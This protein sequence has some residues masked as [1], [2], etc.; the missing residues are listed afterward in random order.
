M[1]LKQVLPLLGVVSISAFAQAPLTEA[2]MLKYTAKAEKITIGKAAKL[3]LPLHAQ[4]N[5][6]N[7]KGKNV[8]SQTVSHPNASYIKLHFKDV[9][10]NNG[11]TLIVRSE[12]GSERYE[13]SKLNM[14]AA[15]QLEGENGTHSFYAMSISA[16]KVVVEYVVG[17][18][19]NS[20]A[21][22]N[23]TAAV[24]ATIDGYYYGAE[25]EIAPASA[26]DMGTFSTCGAMER[27]DVQCWA[28]SNPTEFERT[29]PV[30]RLLMGGT[31]LCTGWRVGSDNRMFTNNHCV[32]STAEVANTE[33]WFNYQHT[34]CN[35]S[36]MATVVKVTG[37]ELL[38]TDYTLDYSLFTINNFEKAAPFGYFGLDVRDATQGERIYIPQH[39]AG[40]PKELSV[41]SDQDPSGL[42][43]VNE[44]NAT[45]RGTGTDLGYYCDTIG[46]SSGSP[47]LAA[48]TNKVIALHHLGGCT[49]KGAKISL[50]WPQVSSHF[51]GQIP[52]GDNG[53]TD[54][55]DPTDPVEPVLQ[56]GVAIGISGA[57]KSEQFFSFDVPANKAIVSFSLTGGSGDADLYVS[58][59]AKPTQSSYTC[60]PYK[61]G[62]EEVCTINNP[63]AGTWHVM[64]HGYQAYSGVSLKAETQDGNTSCGAD[65]LENG[66]PKTGLSGASKSETVYKIEVPAGVTLNVSTSGGTG[67]ADLYVKKGQAP[68][69]SDYDCRPYKNGNNESCSIASGT[70]GTYYIMLRGYNTYSG[71]TLTAS[72]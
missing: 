17:Q 22:E 54:P 29:R 49:N 16:D 61:N 35:G 46:G 10:L 19:K 59:G 13:Y 2:Q 67:D 31:G 65:C 62:N 72:Y 4:V 24:T 23:N 48:Q 45:G 63:T 41:E 34:S 58:Q 9:D 47:V 36:T 53:P 50:I 42:C 7:A 70:G 44:A 32:E 69:T 11:R 26:Q 8:I 60:R 30:A 52:N 71:L 57:A 28:E 20:A 5:T 6:F 39:G 55:T 56:D 25:H 18:K 66:V 64:V 38:K 12:D 3:N 14:S 33:V 68:T 40:N 15:T 1:R 27:K 21:I 43:S 37:K 51:N